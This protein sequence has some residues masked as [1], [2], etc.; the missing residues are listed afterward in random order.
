MRNGCKIWCLALCLLVLASSCED[1]PVCVYANKD[2][3]VLNN[4][5]FDIIVIIRDNFNIQQVGAMGPFEFEEYNVPYNVIIEAGNNTFS[6]QL[7]VDPCQR[8]LELV[9]ED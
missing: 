1:A 9:V 4:T 6:K 7:F 5:G 8:D 2:V 3:T